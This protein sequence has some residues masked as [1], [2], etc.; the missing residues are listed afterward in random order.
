[1]NFL[2]NTLPATQTWTSGSCTLTLNTTTG[3]LTITGTGAMADYTSS[4]SVPWQGNFAQLIKVIKV[5]SGV[6]KIGNGT[7]WDDR[8][9]L[10]GLN[11][12]YWDSGG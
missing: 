12:I 10:S 5:G 4:S 6:T 11:R 9:L 7:F 1:M 3:L 8:N 2:Y